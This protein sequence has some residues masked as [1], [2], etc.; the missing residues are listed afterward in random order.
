[1]RIALDE[2]EQMG[3]DAPGLS[4]SKSLYDQL[5]EKGEENSGTQAIYKYWKN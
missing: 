4:L 1:M 5:A 3:M 2:A